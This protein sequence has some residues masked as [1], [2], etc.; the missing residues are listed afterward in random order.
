VSG[1]TFGIWNWVRYSAQLHAAAPTGTVVLPALMIMVGVQLLL[2]A[3]QYD[4]EAVPRDPVN[5]GP[6]AAGETPP[7]VRRSDR[8]D[9]GI[10]ARTGA[11][12]GEGERPRDADLPVE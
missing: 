1:L 5:Q 6:I 11:G 7:R 8:T 9:S 10:D 2:S 12:A 4:L 3:A